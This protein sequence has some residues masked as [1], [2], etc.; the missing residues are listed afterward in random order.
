[1]YIALDQIEKGE[2]PTV[3]D[4][5]LVSDAVELVDNFYHGGMTTLEPTR[6]ITDARQALFDSHVRFRTG[7][8]IRFTGPG[9]Q[10]V[11]DVIGQYYN[12]L[13]TVPRTHGP[14]TSP[15]DGTRE[16]EIPER[17]QRS[18]FKGNGTMTQLTISSLITELTK[19][20]AEHGD[21]PMVLVDADTG[22]PFKLG[23]K[24]LNVD[25]RRY[26]QK[27]LEFAADYRDDHE[28]TR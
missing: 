10:A 6:S 11:R 22:W 21:L 25:R 20:Q 16:H 14:P 5:A 24:H 9:M 15:R 26:F 18:N 12:I 28:E 3:D 19:I 4:L 13:R 2:N 23:A 17:G 1:M 7:A 27:I 8:S